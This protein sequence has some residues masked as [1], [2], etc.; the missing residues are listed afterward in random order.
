MPALLLWVLSGRSRSVAASFPDGLYGIVGEAQTT[1]YAALRQLSLGRS[2]ME[3][4]L[5]KADWA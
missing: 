5:S 4:P 1:I 3:S 2:V